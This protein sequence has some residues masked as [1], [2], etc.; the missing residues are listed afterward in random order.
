MLR[1]PPLGRQQ[2]GVGWGGEGGKNNSRR[3]P[4]VQ[5]GP[6]ESLLLQYTL[7]KIESHFISIQQQQKKTVS[8]T[9]TLLTFSKGCY[10][11]LQ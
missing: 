9:V 5:Y 10:L 1:L 8:W 2:G 3:I 6:F 7:T 11:Q 4:S